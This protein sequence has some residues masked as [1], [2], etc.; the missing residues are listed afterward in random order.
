MISRQ[1]K[2][3]IL[4]RFFH[5]SLDRSDSSNLDR[6]VS[7][8]VGEYENG[9]ESKEGDVIAHRSMKGFGHGGQVVTGEMADQA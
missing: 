7:S 2:S 4:T 6:I 8:I 9:D 5:H 1:R 3:R